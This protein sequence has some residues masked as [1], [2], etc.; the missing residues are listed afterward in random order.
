MKL[1]E[2]LTTLGGVEVKDVKTWENYRRDEIMDLFCRYVYGIRDIERPENLYFE[3]T[4]EIEEYGMRVKCIKV[5]FDDFA[6][7]FKLYLPKKQNGPLP[8][9]VYVMHENMEKFFRYDD[10]G[11][12]YRCDESEATLP[13]KDITDRGFAVAAM[14]TRE[15]YPEW[16]WHAE[17]KKGVFAHVK[18]PMGRNKHSWASL[19]A[20]AWGASRVIDYLETDGDIDCS[21]ICSIGHSRSGKAALWAGV[22]DQR[23]LLAVPN[24]SGCMGAAVLRDKKGE[25]AVDIN[26]SDWLCDKF[27][28]YNDCEE[29]LPVDQHMLCALMAPR[30]LYITSSIEDE[31]ADPDAEFLSAQLASCAYELYGL[32]GLVA[33]EKPELNK[34]YHEG[35]IAYH[36]KSGD[37][38]QTAFDWDNAMDYFEKITAEQK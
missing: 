31:W 7:N 28:E 25:H 24:N 13:L 15:I 19:S 10:K 14:P 29:L 34:V 23:I 5:G 20:W 37:H 4:G 36:V 26:I 22:T 12:M 35:R 6:F 21:K 17:F 33:P 2:I 8:V 16:T 27:H 18:T 9:F 1:P 38:S 11:N 3:N 32:K 30:Y